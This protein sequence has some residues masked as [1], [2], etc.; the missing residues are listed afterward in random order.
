[1][2]RLAGISC[3]L[4]NLLQS[5]T[6]I[7]S[8][9]GVCGWSRFSYGR[10]GITRNIRHV[11]LFGMGRCSLWCSIAQHLITSVLDGSVHIFSQRRGNSLKYL[12]MILVIE[13]RRKTRFHDVHQPSL[14]CKL[15][16]LNCQYI[17]LS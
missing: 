14:W 16:C 17:L 8:K 7:R 13:I 10:Y 3:F 9:T 4:V 12:I 2:F 1:M 15:L 6:C 5:W 11:N